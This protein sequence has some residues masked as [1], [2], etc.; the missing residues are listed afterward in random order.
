MFELAARLFDPLAMAIVAGGS[1]GVAALRSTGQDIKRAMAAL[2]PLA[3]A[4]PDRDAA[5]C[6]IALRQIERLVEL[7]GI[8]C[9]DRVKSEDHFIR[10][11]AARLAD[12][13]SAEA[14]G[15]WAAEEIEQRRQR[16]ESAL[17]FWQ[18][19]GDAAPSLGMIGTV[20]GLVGTF[21]A[22]TDPARI[23]PAMALAMLTTFYGLIF[24]TLVFGAVAAR[25]ERLSIAERQ[26]QQQLLGH[27]QRLARGE[28]VSGESW[29]RQHNRSLK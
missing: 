26:W 19:A 1:L 7:K 23:G 18:Y 11:A 28:R 10:T 22:M 15:E 16:H 3:C 24:G 6:R 27:L 2:L 21:A 8:A 4:H 25:L 29:L 20:V 14:F 17:A 12:T 5:S 13:S 9:A